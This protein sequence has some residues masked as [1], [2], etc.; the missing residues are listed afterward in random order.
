[1]MLFMARKAD[2]AAGAYSC[3]DDAAAQ[4]RTRPRHAQAARRVWCVAA[5][6]N[7][8][9]TIR[10]YVRDKGEATVTHVL[11]AMGLK[12]KRIISAEAS[13]PLGSV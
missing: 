11:Q 4:D 9:S 10:L 8:L 13:G 6:D 7:A 12:K 5:S 3:E 2:R 1:M